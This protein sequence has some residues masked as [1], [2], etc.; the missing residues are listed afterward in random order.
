MGSRDENELILLGVL[1][2]L[3]DTLMILFN[4]Q[5]EKRI[6]LEKAEIMF[7]V[8]DELIDNGI[9]LEIDPER[10]AERTHVRTTQSELLSE[11]TF[12]QA[13]HNAK[14]QVKSFLR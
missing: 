11:H 1:E 2:C 6:L 13:L 5:I 7:V 3:Y 12:V 9:I 14:E 8:V 4:N 10:L